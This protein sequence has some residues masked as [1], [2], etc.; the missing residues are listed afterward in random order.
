MKD[1]KQEKEKSF[2]EYVKKIEELEKKVA[3]LE[4]ECQGLESDFFFLNIIT[5]PLYLFFF[6]GINAREIG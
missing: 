3:T 2:E 1:M 4:R 6:K 5:S